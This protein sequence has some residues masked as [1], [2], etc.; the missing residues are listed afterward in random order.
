MV[1]VHTSIFYVFAHICIKTSLVLDDDGTVGLGSK[2]MTIKVLK[3]KT[4]R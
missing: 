4:V 3:A 1:H 2:G